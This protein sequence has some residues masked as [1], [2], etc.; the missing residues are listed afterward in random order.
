MYKDIDGTCGRHGIN[1]KYM[2]YFG[3]KPRK[4]DNIKMDIE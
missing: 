1:Y 2:Q 4:K 3:R